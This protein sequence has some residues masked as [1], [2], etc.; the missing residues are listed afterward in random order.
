MLLRTHR[1]LATSLLCSAL[2]PGHQEQRIPQWTIVEPAVQ[3]LGRA[4][5]DTSQQFGVVTGGFLGADGMIAIGDGA[6]GSIRF[7]RSPGRLIR[8]VGRT[9]SGPG[10]FRELSWVG[11]CGPRA[12]AAFDAP[13]LQL[14][15]FDSSGQVALVRRAPTPF[16]VLRP[17]TCRANGGIIAVFDS[18]G[19]LPEQSGIFR[20]PGLLISID[21]DFL[22]SDTIAVFPGSE[23]Y[24]S[25]EVGG[26]GELPLGLTSFAAAGPHVA[27]VAR[28]DSPWISIYQV[29]SRDTSRVHVPLTPHQV[30]QTEFAA[31]V[32]ARVADESTPRVRQLL[33][34]VYASA[35]VPRGVR[36][37]RQLAVD[38]L[39]QVWIE[40]W[41]GTSTDMTVWLVV[42]MRGKVLGR[43]KL[44]AAARI[45]YA[46]GHDLLLRLPAA[47]GPETVA[48]YRL[49]K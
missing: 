39:D 48:L 32:A 28:N 45:L 33:T 6:T 43:I 35:P 41:E 9:G 29:L 23:R 26:Y 27:V 22:T 12:F 36:Y 19:T 37:L 20:T 16:V 18:P 14:T 3:L 8:S 10:E 11:E 25:R 21:R 1:Q 7:F 40:T 49:R 46:D 2:G 44:P 31:A 17:L 4:P 42:D 30:T 38:E 24:V 15:R 5:Q 13:A 34:R 47:D